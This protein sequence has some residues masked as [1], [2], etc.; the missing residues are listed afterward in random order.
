MFSKQKHVEIF[1]ISNNM[2]V[3]NEKLIFPNFSCC[4]KIWSSKDP[5]V[6]FSKKE[7]VFWHFWWVFWCSYRILIH[8]D[9]VHIRIRNLKL[10]WKWIQK[11]SRWSIISRHFR[12]LGDSCHKISISSWKFKKMRKVKKDSDWDQTKN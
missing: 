10:S 12:A 5:V 11:S 6:A 2:S 3:K 9:T 1:I 4:W 8:S 7:I